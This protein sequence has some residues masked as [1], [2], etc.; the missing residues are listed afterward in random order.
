MPFHRHSFVAFALYS[1]PRDSMK[2]FLQK[3]WSFWLALFSCIAFLV[4]NM[5]GQH[6]WG[7]F[8]KSVWGK[9]TEIHIVFEGATTPLAKVPDPA[10]WSPATNHE[11]DFSAVPKE[12]LI[13]LPAY[14]ASPHCEEEDHSHEYEVL[15]VD[16]N[17]S[18]EVRGTGCGSHPAAD[19]LTPRGT[20]VI[21]VMNGIVDRVEERSWGFGNTVV[22]RHPNVPDPDHPEAKTTLY[23]SYAHLGAIS[24]SVGQVMKKGQQIAV[25]GQT[26]F[27]TAPHLHFQIDKVA[28]PFHPYWP[29]TT[30][31]ATQAGYTFTDAVNH[32]L[33]KE[34]AQRY[35]V[36]PLAYVQTY[37]E[38]RE[39]EGIAEQGTGKQEV[40]SDQG[41]TPGTALAGE[42][43]KSVKERFLSRVRSLFA[44]SRE[45]RRATRISR[46]QERPNPRSAIALQSSDE[47]LVPVISSFVATK[48]TVVEEE[49]L[50]KNLQALAVIHPTVGAEV[51][52]TAETDIPMPVI[53]GAVS[54]IT[55]LHDGEFHND[56]EEIV[57]YARDAEG[58]FV[59]DVHFAGTISFD[60]AFGVAEFSP[61]SITEE[62]F[63]ERGRAIIRMLPRQNG[64]RAIV[65]VL[66]GAFSTRGEPLAFNPSEKK[67]NDSIR[68]TRSDG[69]TT[70][71]AVSER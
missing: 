20:P 48:T 18:Y 3:R 36:N 1:E 26:G 45:A 71:T 37:G 9:E 15:S 10:R 59:R 16:Y 66:S 24:V 7:A 12:M 54:E 57:L 47:A 29:F 25:S 55:I 17:G 60:T 46:L 44:A 62:Q 31:E 49:T 23:S 32:G 53:G 13:P 69:S 52:S 35:T 21:S 33:G 11:S 61:S 2:G 51:L 56:W 41:T 34:N 38:W 42:K 67:G 5:V 40:A 8:W 27:A 6:G 65:P 39:K 70:E 64:N 4:G 30:T 68:T 22:I 28:A 19:I 63:D 58:Q 14:T 50:D 43:K